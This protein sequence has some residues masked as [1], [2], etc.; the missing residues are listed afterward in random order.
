MKK[1]YLFIHSQKNLNSF[2]KNLEKQISALLIRQLQ[3]NQI[4]MQKSGFAPEKT[5]PLQEQPTRR[6]K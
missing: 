4:I 1:K 6:N 3:E 5:D 2:S